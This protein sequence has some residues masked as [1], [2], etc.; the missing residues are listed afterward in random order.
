[1]LSSVRAEVPSHLVRAVCLSLLMVTASGCERTVE[2]APDATPLASWNLAPSPEVVLGAVTGPEE[3]LFTRLSGGEVLPDGRIALADAGS[4]EIRVFEPSGALSWQ[5]GGEGDGPG[6]FRRLAWIRLFRDKLAALD[7]GTVRLSFF[8]LDGQHLR[9]E[10]LNLQ[11]APFP[12]RVL[13]ALPDGRVFL[14]LRTG[15]QARSAPPEFEIHSE[16]FLVTLRGPRGEDTLG[17]FPGPEIF[18]AVKGDYLWPDLLPFG[19]KRL[20]Q[21]GDSCLVLGFGNENRLYVIH[22]RGAIDTIPSATPERPLTEEAYARARKDF[23]EG[24]EGISLDLMTMG[25]EGAPRPD[26]MPPYDK[27]RIDSDGLIWLR[28]YDPGRNAHAWFVQDFSGRGIATIQIPD[29]LTVMDVAGSRVLTRSTD[30]LGVQRVQLWRLQ[31]EDPDGRS[32][33]KSG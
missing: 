21:P 10:R 19:R 31:G 4:Q 9:T 3:I 1:M 2:S 13:S 8:S 26:L 28:Q 22:S 20:L 5:V 15:P 32:S 14:E 17:I 33:D 12:S 23:L 18:T 24:E 7:L 30:F 27:I 11:N 25:F 16:P 6:E 29:S